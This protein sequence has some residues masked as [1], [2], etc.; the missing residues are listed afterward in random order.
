MCKDWAKIQA[1]HFEHIGSRRC[2]KQWTAQLA[3]KLINIIYDM[4]SHRNEVLHK[5]DNIVTEKIHKELNSTIKTIFS[6]LPNMRL[7]SEAERRFFKFSTSQKVQ[8][9]QMHRKRQ[10]IKKAESILTHLEAKQHDK[11]IGNAHILLRAI[12]IHTN[13]YKNDTSKRKQTQNKNQTKTTKNTTIT[14]YNKKQQT[15]QNYMCND[16][17]KKQKNK[18]RDL[19]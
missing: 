18:V 16:K 14:K 5:A 19:G 2:P 1:T 9:L 7:L 15:I 4:W 13:E 3:E 10:W 17:Y 6:Q 11:S 8:E 12:G